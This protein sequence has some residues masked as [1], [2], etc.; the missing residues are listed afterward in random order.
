MAQPQ[1][2]HLDAVKHILRYIKKTADYGLFYTSEPTAPP[3]GSGGG[4][5]C[6]GLRSNVS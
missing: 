5:L 1:L 6:V 4:V 2:S 3:L